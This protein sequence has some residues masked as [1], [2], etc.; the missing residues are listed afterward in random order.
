MVGIKPYRKIEERYDRTALRTLIKTG[1][2]TGTKAGTTGTVKSLPLT[3]EGSQ[4]EAM[5]ILPISYLHDIS[6]KRLVFLSYI[7]SK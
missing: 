4:I 7:S 5:T 3:P 1:L 2:R 6:I